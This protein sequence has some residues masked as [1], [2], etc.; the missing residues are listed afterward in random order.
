MQ[1]G[2]SLLHHMYVG[3]APTRRVQL[4][5]NPPRVYAA[6]AAVSGT[7][8]EHIAHC[9]SRHEKVEVGVTSDDLAGEQAGDVFGRTRSRYRY[10]SAKG[11]FL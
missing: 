11:F 6:R 8:E 1:E 9:S 7:S 10:A 5:D 3:F 4:I 2:M